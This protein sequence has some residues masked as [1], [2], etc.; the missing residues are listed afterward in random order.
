LESL[1]GAAARVTWTDLGLISEVVVVE[2][3][4]DLDVVDDRTP[5]SD[6]FSVAGYVR[7]IHVLELVSDVRYHIGL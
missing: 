3:I 6:G 4:I 7:V 5:F 1:A 2:W